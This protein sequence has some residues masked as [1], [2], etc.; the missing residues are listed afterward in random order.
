MTIESRGIPVDGQGDLQAET[1]PTKIQRRNGQQAQLHYGYHTGSGVPRASQEKEVL[2]Y[3][4]IESPGGRRE[5]N[6]DGPGEKFGQ[7]AQAAGVEAAGSGGPQDCAVPNSIAPVAGMP[8]QDETSPRGYPENV[9]GGRAK[10]VERKRCCE[11][12]DATARMNLL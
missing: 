10:S 3:D 2:R 8:P 4:A 5:C 7:Q 9:Q 12:A 11:T 1:R 6:H